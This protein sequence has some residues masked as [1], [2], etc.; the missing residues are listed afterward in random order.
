[1]REIKFRAWNKEA[2]IMIDLYEITPLA[3][4][5]MM[6]TQLHMQN[7]TGLFIPFIKQLEIMQF[8]GLSDRNNINIY[9]N[10]IV[11]A[12]I[13]KCK[14]IVKFGEYKSEELSGRLAHGYYLENIIYSTFLEDVDVWHEGIQ[15]SYVYLEVVGN[16]YN[17]PELL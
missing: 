9:E 7:G 1:M 13:N 2:K 10:D 16:I 12:P 11:F 14:Y 3:L 6:S 8:T 17:N 15:Q 4:S 5:D